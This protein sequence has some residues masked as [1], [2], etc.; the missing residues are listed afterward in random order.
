MKY[1]VRILVL[2]ILLIIDIVIVCEHDIL[3]LILFST[4]VLII[5]HINTFNN[6]YILQSNKKP[7]E[8]KMTDDQN[9][10]SWW[11]QKWT[12]EFRF[13]YSVVISIFINSLISFTKQLLSTTNNIFIMFQEV[14]K[15]WVERNIFL[16]FSQNMKIW[17]K[18]I[19]LLTKNI[20]RCIFQKCRIML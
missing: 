7:I 16:V 9:K 10:Y 20:T 14:H 18:T 3:Y 8:Y 2:K 13:I 12:V 6:F 17:H 15:E 11:Q 1:L 4:F 5:L 19:T